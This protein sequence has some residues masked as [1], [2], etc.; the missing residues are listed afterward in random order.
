MK[1]NRMKDEKQQR[2]P[3]RLRLN[4]ETI[5]VLNDPAL[6]ELARGGLRFSE[7]ISAQEER[8]VNTTSTNCISGDTSC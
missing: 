1:R 7:Q 3:R 6:L 8:C 5:Q 2:K 4:R